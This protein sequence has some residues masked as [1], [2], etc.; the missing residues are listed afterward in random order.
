MAKNFR[1]HISRRNNNLYLDLKGDFDGTSAYQLLETLKKYY[2]GDGKVI[3]NTK[4]LSCVVPFGVRVF[5]SDLHTTRCRRKNI[6][7]IGKS[8][9]YQ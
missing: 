6:V 7:F 1:I 3:I 5:R 8:S 9:I 4:S 2:H